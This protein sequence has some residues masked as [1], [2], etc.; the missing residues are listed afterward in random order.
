TFNIMLAYLA[1]RDFA[2]GFIPLVEDTVLAKILGIN[3]LETAVKT[4][5]ARRLEKMDLAVIGDNYFISQVEFGIASTKVKNMG[6]FSSISSLTKDFYNLKLRIDNSYTMDITCLGGT[7]TNSRTTSS[8]N[9]SIANPTDGFLDLMVLER[10]TRM[11]VLKYK[12]DIAKGVMENIP[13]TSVIKCRQVEFLE[14]RGFPLNIAGRT[15]A[16]VPAVVSIIPRQ[17]RMI[18]GKGRTF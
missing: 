7:V 13:G 11:D 16:K 6:W 12:P 1:G 15:F 9:S 10:L 17:L 2:L 14:P 3:S 8:S 18:V 4:V 5:A